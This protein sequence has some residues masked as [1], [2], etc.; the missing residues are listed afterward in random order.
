[1]GS[2]MHEEEAN[3]MSSTEE[4]L[5]SIETTLRFHG[6]AHKEISDTVKIMDTKLDALLLQQAEKSGEAKAIKR[7]SA[8][9]S[10]AVS[11]TLTLIVTVAVA[12]FFK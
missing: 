7:V 3:C 4:R 6:E 1:M 8:L 9:I 5:S 2:G 10:A 11:L 12:Y